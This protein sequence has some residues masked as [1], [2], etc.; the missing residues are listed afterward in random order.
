MILWGMRDS[1]AVWLLFIDYCLLII[2]L[3]FIDNCK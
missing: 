2:V 1:K 3:L